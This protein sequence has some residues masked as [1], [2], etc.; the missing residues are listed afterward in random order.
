[1]SEDW[2]P[3]TLPR[4]HTE[5]NRLDAEHRGYKVNVG[6]LLHPRIREALPTNAHQF[7]KERDGK[8]EYGLLNVLKDVPEHHKAKFDVFHLRLLICGLKT[9]DWQK[10]ARHVLDL[11]KPGGWIQWQDSNFPNLKCY[12][13]KPGASRKACSGLL[14]PVLKALSAQDKFMP[15][16]IT[17]LMSLV[18]NAGFEDCDED[19]SSSDRVAE[20]RATNNVY[21]Q[22]AV[23]TLGKVLAQ[24]GAMPGWT[25][26]QVDA[27]TARCIEELRDAKVYWRWDF[28]IV[29][30]KKGP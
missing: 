7:P 23:T 4:D 19:V 28:H 6:Y 12:N 14:S 26:E 16:S 18:Q 20:T 3:Y 30:G 29:T 21:Q 13:N 22:D 9:R 11:L 17:G 8:V 1:M 5:S 2:K 15:H 10:A 25:K 27:V 24:Q